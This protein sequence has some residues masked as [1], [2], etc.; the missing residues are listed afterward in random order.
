[1][2][3]IVITVAS[4]GLGSALWPA[5]AL[6][7][8][9]A[10]GYCIYAAIRSIGRGILRIIKGT[11]DDFGGE[12]HVADAPR[13]WKQFVP[14]KPII[15]RVSFNKDERI[16]GDILRMRAIERGVLKNDGFVLPSGG[17]MI[18]EEDG[19]MQFVDSRFRGYAR[20]QQ[21]SDLSVWTPD[22]HLVVMRTRRADT[23]QNIH[24]D[25]DEGRLALTSLLGDIRHV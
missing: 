20:M 22:H 17:R 7:G 4:C 23:F 14:P 9:I 21:N 10:A 8:V 1:M 2:E 6:F 13:G 24:H 5:I 19:T 25:S 11:S 16:R 3:T 18:I 15:I 12:S